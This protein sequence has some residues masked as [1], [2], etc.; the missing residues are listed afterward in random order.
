MCAA[1]PMVPH[2]AIVRRPEPAGNIATPVQMNL[3]D[4]QHDAKLRQNPFRLLLQLRLYTFLEYIRCSRARSAQWSTPTT[5]FFKIL[6]QL[7][8]MRTYAEDSRPWKIWF[9]R[10]NEDASRRPTFFP[11]LRLVTTSPTRYCNFLRKLIF[12]T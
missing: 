5:A 10:L 8:P 12:K 9:R 7:S 2:V 4:R 3:L 6:P 11:L 1:W